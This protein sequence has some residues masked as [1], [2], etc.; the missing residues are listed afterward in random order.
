MGK[1]R[2]RVGV[3]FDR[4]LIEVLKSLHEPELTTG[5]RSSDFDKIFLGEG[6]ERWHETVRGRLLTDGYLTADLMRA[7]RQ[8]R[9]QRTPKCPNGTLSQNTTNHLLRLSRSRFIKRTPVAPR[10]VLNFC[11]KKIDDYTAPD[12]DQSHLSQL[13]GMVKRARPQDCFH[14]LDGADSGV[15]LISP[16]VRGYDRTHLERYIREIRSFVWELTK[17]WERQYAT[18]HLEQIMTLDDDLNTELVGMKDL[19]WLAEAERTNPRHH[20]SKNEYRKMISAKRS[21]S[22]YDKWLIDSIELYATV[23][24]KAEHLRMKLEHFQKKV[25][26]PSDE[27][28]KS[29]TRRLQ[30]IDRVV[31]F[32]PHLPLIIVG[33]SH[34][35]SSYPAIIGA[36]RYQLLRKP[37]IL[38]RTYPAGDP[39]VGGRVLDTVGLSSD[40]W[41]ELFR[42]IGSGTENPDDPKSVDE[43]IASVKNGAQIMYSEWLDRV[44]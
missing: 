43:L 32:L 34:R 39:T 40:A 15:S 41:A 44:R 29:I 23:Y 1:P 42:C 2:E 25:P 11:G 5:I 18:D 20:L 22:E 27:G 17:D 6:M 12:L 3:D 28:E 33:P 9:E 21:H 38:V 36:R 30:L 4:A 19:S 8:W 14:N 13:D 16:S 7:V 35:S 26:Q 37:L 10:K 31:H 24:R